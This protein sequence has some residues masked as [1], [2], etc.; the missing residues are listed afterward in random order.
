[1]RA[2]SRGRYLAP[3][4]LLAAIIAVGAVLRSGLSKHHAAPPTPTTALTTSGHHATHKKF[5]V[6]RAGDTLS[7]I[8]VKTGIPVA[9]LESLNRVDPSTLQAGQRLKLSP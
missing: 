8:S 3:I 7:G 9:T 1:M 4:A 5:Y 2:R 6:V